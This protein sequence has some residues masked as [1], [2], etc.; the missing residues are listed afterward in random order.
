MQESAK[1]SLSLFDKRKAEFMREVR[2]E[3][4]MKHMQAMHELRG[5]LMKQ[6]KQEYETQLKA[7]GS[8]QGKG[9]TVVDAAEEF[10][11]LAALAQNAQDFKRPTAN[12]SIQTE[13]DD[14]GLW[15][16]KDGW[17][18]PITGTLLARQRW[19]K[20]LEFAK[21]PQCRGIGKFIGYVAILLKQMQRGQPPVEDQKNSKK[22]LKWSVPDELTRFMSNLPKSAQAINPKG[23][24]WAFKMVWVLVEEKSSAVES[25][26]ALGY[27]IQTAPEFLIEAFL[28]RGESR[29]EAEIEM[30]KLIITMKESYRKHPLLQTF[31]RFAG[32]LDGLSLNDKKQLE[33][34]RKREKAAIAKKQLDDANLKLN[35][36]ER[37]KAEA[38][39]AE[40]KESKLKQLKQ[41]GKNNDEDKDYKITERAL[42]LGVMTVYL[43]ARQCLMHQPYKGIYAARIDFMKKNFEELKSFQ[44][45]VEGDTDW[46]VTIPNHICV[47]ESYECWV[48]LDRGLR[49]LHVLTSFLAEEEKQ[50]ILHSLEY[51]T[52][53]MN[54]WGRLAE[55]QGEH[56]NLRLLFRRLLNSA[57]EDGH[58]LTWEEIFDSN[59]AGGRKITAE[60]RSAF[61]KSETTMPIKLKLGSKKEED[62]KERE[63]SKSFGENVIFFLNLD[64]ILQI[65]IEALL[66]RSEFVEKTLGKIFIDGDTNGDG[67][68]SFREFTDIVSKVAPH[69]H[70]RRILK[71]FR[72]ALMT[73]N[74]DETIGPEAFVD[75]CK[76]H[77]LVQLID[78][79]A[80]REGE[81]SALCHH[82]HLVDDDD[83]YK[84]STGTQTDAMLPAID[85]S[86][87]SK[88]VLSKSVK[89]VTAIRMS[90]KMT[91][92]MN[93]KNNDSSE[94][95]Q[96]DKN[97]YTNT[98]INTNI[99]TNT[100]SDTNSNY[101]ATNIEDNKS[102]RNNGGFDDNDS[103][104]TNTSSINS[105]T[106]T[107]T[108]DSSLQR[109]I[110]SFQSSKIS[111]Q[112]NLLTGRSN[113]TDRSKL[114]IFLP[115][116][117]QDTITNNTNLISSSDNYSNIENN[118]TKSIKNNLNMKSLVT[119]VRN[120]D[121]NSMVIRHTNTNDTT[122]RINN[123]NNNYII[124]TNT[125]T[126]PIPIK[127]EVSHLK[128]HKNES[129]SKILS[130][131]ITNKLKQRKL[132][133]KQDDFNDDDS[134]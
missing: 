29:V 43:F 92:Y 13:V 34:E 88:N 17:V 76:K 16:K 70:E 46:K 51:N 130:E 102:Y 77:G 99:N 61:I 53:V 25:D 118:D 69:F 72:E 100:L 112:N 82:L 109:V 50:K 115:A 89:A 18:L 98:S 45:K 114:D 4:R 49:V 110:A 9:A 60:E 107:N 52:K 56:S 39:K 40:V 59:S 3:E 106:N 134:Y 123:N 48:P 97:T 87:S 8:N 81:L 64:H 113:S 111:L 80:Y 44:S 68:L 27:V 93:A 95:V 71:M 11:K 32:C 133:R 1:E 74:D 6:L 66:F 126:I 75:V 121:Q 41:H 122:N 103:V 90:S 54:E 38:E 22:G 104:N 67:V 116:K 12:M 14:L 73:G 128:L 47:S 42:S 35:A 36:R 96:D 62:E 57:S 24:L 21:C 58:D 63:Q 10:S 23:V 28:L 26:N 119:K 31:A 20:A 30:Y 55:P 117:I 84:I 83:I 108:S 86:K 15:D 132:M 101:S 127:S 37:S 125:N 5:R 79:H 7:A 78:V 94:A 85:K 105:E 65:L 2:D 120:D 129:I 91:K 19:R 124:T 131:D 33:L